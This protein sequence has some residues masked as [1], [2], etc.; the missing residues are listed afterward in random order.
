MRFFGFIIIAGVLLAVGKLA[1]TLMS[2][3]LLM[4]CG[5]AVCFRTRE[6]LTVLGFLLLSSLLMTHPGWFA[7]LI[8][9][10]VFHRWL[11]KDDPEPTPETKLLP[12]PTSDQPHR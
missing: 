11:E 3:A 12:P 1:A 5:W 8:G 6:V 4:L 7:L 9:L 10:V 2:L